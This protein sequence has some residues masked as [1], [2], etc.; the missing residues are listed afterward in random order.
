MRQ[1]LVDRFG[2][3]EETGSVPEEVENLFFQIRIK[4]LATRAGIDKV[5]RE[6][7]HLVLRSDALENMDRRLLQRRLRMHLGHIDADDGSFVPDEGAKVAR[8]A[9]HLPIDDE[10]QWQPALVRTLQIMAIG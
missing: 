2:K 1:E 4:I 5:S 7:D 3:D 10:G 9:I 8:R 6:L